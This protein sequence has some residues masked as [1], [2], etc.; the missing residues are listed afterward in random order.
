M[1]GSKVP[2]SRDAEQVRR[3]L[4]LPEVVALIATLDETRWTGR[5]GYPVRAMVGMALV[6]SLYCIPV[7]TRVVRLVADHAALQAVLGCAPSEWACYRFTRKLREND[8]ALQACLDAVLTS[9]HEVAPEMGKVVA[10]DGSDLPAYANGQRRLSKNGP[11]RTKF[12]D[13]DASWGHRSSVG[14]RSGGG[15]YGF[16]VH[17]MVDAATELPLAWVVRTAKDSEL[18]EVEGLLDRVKERGFRP[19][20]VTL[21]KNYDAAD[22]Y[23]TVMDRGAKP[24]IPLI[25]TARVKRGEHL[26]PTCEHGEWTFA[27]ADDKRGATQWRCP[28]AECSPRSVWLPYDRLH[29]AIPRSTKRWGDLYRKRTSVERGFG[30]FKNESG[31]LPLRVR[32]IHRVQQHVDLTILTMLASAL[33]QARA[34]PA[35]A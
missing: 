12:A 9:L 13:P 29:T 14:T 18:P 4:A 24:V 10:G 3:L 21:D 16:K 25:K 1:A 6:K 28:T 22:I 30:R 27:G 35:V 11:L 32:R 23:T 5:K 19:A 20:V 8:D 34:L 26:P 2:P 7:W 17:A 31:G 33:V 15:Y